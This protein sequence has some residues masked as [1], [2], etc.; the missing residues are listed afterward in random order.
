MT[1]VSRKLI[2]LMNSSKY[3]AQPPYLIIAGGTVLISSSNPFDPP[4]VNPNLL[5]SDF[6]IFAMRD[7][8]RASRRFAQ[9]PVF[10][11]YVLS[12]VDTAITDTE[13]DAF[14]RET[15]IT[16]SHAVGTAA[17]S[18]KGADYGVV[19]PD[20]RVKKVVGLRVVDSSVIV[21]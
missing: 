13:L 19:D 10:S 16:V 8:I 6:D 17:M 15:A 5:D 12:L 21:S 11:D 4:A 18:P 2:S 9:A 3:Y 14:I 7:A 20:L 1:P